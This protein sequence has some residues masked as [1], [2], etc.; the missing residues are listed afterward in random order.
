MTWPQLFGEDAGGA[1]GGVS[2]GADLGGIIGFDSDLSDQ[3]GRENVQTVH[4][5]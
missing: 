3:E 4:H 1:P 2:G 5:K